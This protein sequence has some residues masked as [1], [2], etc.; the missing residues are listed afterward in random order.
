LSGRPL[1]SSKWAE[2]G[3]LVEYI[4]QSRGLY[5]QAGKI[6]DR[7]K[8]DLNRPKVLIEVPDTGIR[9]QWDTFFDAIVKPMREDRLS[10]RDAKEAAEADIGELR[11]L[12][13][14]RMNPP[15]EPNRNGKTLK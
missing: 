4:L 11:Q 10:R 12:A 8:H 13:K 2:Q 15:R 5:I 14:F 3:I 7:L 9:T 1:S 6:G